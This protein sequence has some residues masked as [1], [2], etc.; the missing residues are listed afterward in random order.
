MCSAGRKYFILFLFC[1]KTLQFFS[2][3]VGGT[4]SGAASYC[5]SVNSGFISVSGYTGSI[6]FWQFST[7]GG[8]TWTPNGNITA[9]QSYN[10]LTQTTC[11]RA[12]VKNGTFPADTS[13]ISCIT[14]YSPTVAGS[15]SAGGTFCSSAGPGTITLTG[16]NGAVLHWQYSTNGGVTW[17][18]I[19]N[20]TTSLTYTS[21]SQSTIYEA[22]VQNSS[23]C[24]IDTS[25]QSVF[26]IDPVSA[27]G[28]INVTGNDSVCYGINSGT[29]TLTGY[30]GQITGWQYSVNSGATWT[31]ITNTTSIQPIS[32]LTQTTLYQSIVKSGICPVATS[33]TPT[34]TVLPLPT[35]NAGT[36]STI[37][38]GQSVTLNGSGT[39]IPLWSPSTGLTNA[40]LFKPVATPTATTNYILTVTGTNGCVNSDTVLI[41]VIIAVF[42]GIVSNYITPN[43]DGIND[44][45]YIQDIQ[46]Y[47]D[48]E[49]FI[50]NIYGNQVYN[51]KGYTN[52]WKGTY[53]GSELPDGTYYYVLKFNNSGKVIKGSLD[54]MSKK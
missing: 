20:T 42:N 25:S 46:N 3:S 41:T 43:G 8:V 2:Q 40:T 9:N 30:T 5:S 14:I 31:T 29:L 10:N 17:N 38:T 23:F 15:L 1:L 35:V 32:N 33:S 12:V 47:S 39:G 7:N 22:V 24:S 27:G 6:Q 4:T 51:K 19:A 36:D 37:V 34:I 21:I 45:W 26:T 50:Y 53:N 28:V 16:N 52:D 48:N 54:I 44:A 49:V 18:T 11:Y 13:T